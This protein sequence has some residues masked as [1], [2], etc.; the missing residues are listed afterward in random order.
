MILKIWYC[1]GSDCITPCILPFHEDHDTPDS[2][3]WSEE[4]SFRV[5]YMEDKE[6]LRLFKGDQ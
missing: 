5:E 1:F 3:P 6:L 4:S 2:C